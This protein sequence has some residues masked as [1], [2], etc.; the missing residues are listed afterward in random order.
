VA[1][2]S[3]ANALRFKKEASQCPW[4]AFFCL[5]E[6]R[7]KMSESIDME[8]VLLNRL[9]GIG[10][11]PEIIHGLLNDMAN[12][13]LHDPNI[14]LDQINRKLYSLG[15]INNKIDYH[16]FVIAEAILNKSSNKLLAIL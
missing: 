15:W 14:N 12:S 11:E 9:K 2:L 10:V 5:I 4:L 8:K 7:N 3:Q 16:T 13:F 6:E 1:A